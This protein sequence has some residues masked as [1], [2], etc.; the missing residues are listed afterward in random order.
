MQPEKFYVVVRKDLGGFGYQAS[1]GTHA[2]IDYCMTHKPSNWWDISNTIVVVTVESQ[3][4]LLDLTRRALVEG[5]KCVT[6]CEPD[7][8]YEATS[9]AFEPGDK[10]K[11]ICKGLP[12]L[13]KEV[14][15]WNRD[16]VR[17]SLIELQKEFNQTENQTIMEH[18]YSINRYMMDL[19]QY[20][21]NPETSRYNWDGQL[22]DVMV[23]FGKEISAKIHP[24]KD[25]WDYT[26]FHD[27]GKPICQQIIDGKYHFPDHANKSSH[28]ARRKGMNDTV[29]HLIQHDM[30]LHTIK[31]E[32]MPALI[33]LLS[34]EDLISLLVVAFASLMS[35]A[36]QHGG[37][38][39]DSYKIKHKKLCSR[40]KI[41][42][43]HVF[44]SKKGI[45]F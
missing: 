8:N 38:S 20:L 12:L 45:D 16:L 1:Q 7:L 28:V 24:I 13:G 29:C 25:M 21:S 19:L 17:F 44:S 43:S 40:A 15:D 41:I 33:K 37:T 31:A 22:P 30:D 18:G 39:V 11:L 9:A 23:L 3:E 5:V 6:F 34:E 42:M 32:D 10:S 27:C 4:H 2:A 26:I 35:N 14:S 36:E